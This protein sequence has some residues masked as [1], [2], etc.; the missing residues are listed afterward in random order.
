MKTTYRM[1]KSDFLYR[2]I[3][4]HCVNLWAEAFLKQYCREVTSTDAIMQGCY[5]VGK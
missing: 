3:S 5:V 4:P 2:H 1:V